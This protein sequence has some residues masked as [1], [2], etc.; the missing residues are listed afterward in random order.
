[1][2]TTVT[3]AECRNSVVRKWHRRERREIIRI[4]KNLSSA[5]KAVAR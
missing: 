5:Y 1:M 2:R 4:L 3:K